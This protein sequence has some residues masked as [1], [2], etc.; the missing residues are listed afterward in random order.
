[1]VNT[2]VEVAKDRAKKRF[3]ESK[4]AINNVALE[5][6]WKEFEPPKVLYL[7]LNN[8]QVVD[9]ELVTQFGNLVKLLRRGKNI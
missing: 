4:H 8:Y 6:I 3:G 1:M 7:S 2:P 5:L 9:S